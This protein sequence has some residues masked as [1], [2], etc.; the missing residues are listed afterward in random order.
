MNK[1]PHDSIGWSITCTIDVLCQMM[2]R[3]DCHMLVLS[4]T[5]DFSHNRQPIYTKKNFNVLNPKIANIWIIRIVFLYI[6]LL[7]WKSPDLVY[8]T[9]HFLYTDNEQEI[10]FGIERYHRGLES[11]HHLL[12]SF[13]IFVIGI[14]C[15][16][17]D[18]PEC[19]MS[20]DQKNIKDCVFIIRC[21]VIPR[22]KHTQIKTSNLLYMAFSEVEGNCIASF[23]QWNADTR[24]F[25]FQN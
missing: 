6:C 1:H 24:I 9:Y 11:L 3:V 2:K 12:L 4:K 25:F 10:L 23:S 13:A 8:I 21:K 16:D 19:E 15:K 18:F 20:H 14:W 17:T 7:S 22:S 5:D